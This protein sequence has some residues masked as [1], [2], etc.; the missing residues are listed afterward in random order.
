MLSSSSLLTRAEVA[1]VAA[2]ADV[3]AEEAH[4]AGADVEPEVVAVDVVKELADVVDLRL[5]QPAA[6]TTRTAAPAPS[7][8]RA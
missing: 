1:D 4:H 6:A 7:A 2:Q 5:D 3:V 8:P